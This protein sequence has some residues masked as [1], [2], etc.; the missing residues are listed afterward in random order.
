MFLNLIDNL[1]QHKIL[2]AIITI[3]VLLSSIVI[4]WIIRNKKR[5]IK[6]NEVASI[7]VFTAFSIVLYFLKF[8]LPFIFPEF[9]EI[10]FSLLPVIILGY[11]L[12]PVEAITVVLLRAIIKMPF[13]STICVGELADLMIGIPVALITSL[14]Y[15]KMHTRIGALISLGCGIL[16]W[17]IVALFTNYFV[18]VP[19]FL[20]FYCLGNESTFVS[21]LTIIPG[22]NEYNY[23]MKYLLYA[24]VPFNLLISVVVSLVTFLVYKK[25]S[26]LFSKFNK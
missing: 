10:N 17:V 2:V 19:F 15:K 8:N 24:V 6:V 21:I 25:I 16:T 12:G 14:M 13:S 9:L 1:K 22:V 26:I 4:M 3:L 7:G 11:M 18:N 23:M 20:E 5:R